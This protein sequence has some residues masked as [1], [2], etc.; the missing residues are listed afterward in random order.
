MKILW[1]VNSLL[2]EATAF[3]TGQ[4]ELKGSGGWI[5]G[6]AESLQKISNVNIIVVGITTLV[7]DL[8]KIKGNILSYYAI[9]SNGGDRKYNKK[10]EAAYK[11][12][13]EKEKPEVVHIHG[14]E[15]PHSLAAL[16]ACGS[17]NTVIS[18]Q[19]IVS[20]IEPFYLG[21]IKKKELWKCLTIHDL[22]RPNVFQQHRNIKERGDNEIQLFKEAKYIIGRTKWDMVHVWAVN[23]QIVY[24][25]CNEVLRKEFY[26][27]NVWEYKDC[28]PYSIF[29]S[30]GYYPLKGLHKLIMAIGIV[31]IHYTNTRLYIA[32]LNFT[33]NN[34][35][36]LDKIKLSAY[37][38][39]INKL[40]DVYGLKNS[41]IFLGSL[42]A[43]DMKKQYLRS[44]VFV[45]PSSI[46]NSPN[47]LGEAQVLGVPCVAS[48]VG[49]I[50]DMMEGNENNLYRFEDVEMLAKN[51][52]DIF[53]KKEKIPQLDSMRH[54][55]LGRHNAEKVTKRMM[56]IYYTVSKNH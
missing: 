2:P 21:G 53:E 15:Y 22:L 19:G 8:T 52:C 12:I 51:I 32:G 31:K 25:K 38:K 41:V 35:G 4:N 23:P 56:E 48:Y 44:N 18:L 37:G 9:P 10:Y 46:E 34:G 27:G 20:A 47:S 7:Q 11:S 49:G 33:H 26:E 13:F 30:Q 36:I 42:N 54:R 5:Q 55:A 14:T 29:A 45:C 40:I 17:D 50:P 6:L 16:R 39:Y 1:I 28:E 3:L 24:M 43:E